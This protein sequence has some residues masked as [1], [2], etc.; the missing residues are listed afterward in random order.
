MDVVG[1]VLIGD[2]QGCVG[3]IGVAVVLHAR[4]CAVVLG[5]Q[6]GAVPHE[7]GRDTIDRFAYTASE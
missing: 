3:I 5:Y 4:A 7:P 1:A 6:I 2:L